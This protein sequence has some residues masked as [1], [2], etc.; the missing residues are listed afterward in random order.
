MPS[1]SR[2]GKARGDQAA[3]RDDRPAGARGQVAA[4][5]RV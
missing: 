3:L 1:V 4:A 2:L 5:R